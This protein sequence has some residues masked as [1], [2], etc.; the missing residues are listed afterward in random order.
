[1]SQVDV[2]LDDCNAITITGILGYGRS[3]GTYSVQEIR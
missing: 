2:K 1:M 3:H